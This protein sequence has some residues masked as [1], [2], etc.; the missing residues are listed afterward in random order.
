MP[1]ALLESELFGYEAGAFTDARASKK[2]LLEVAEGGTV[3]LDEIGDLE[4]PVQAKLLRVLEDKR[5]R[6][7]GG[8]QDYAANVRFVAATNRPLETLVREGRF[9]QDLYFRLNVFHI[10]VGPLRERKD[11]MVS[12]LDILS[13]SSAAH[14]TSKSTA[15]PLPRNNCW[16]PM[17]GRETSENCAIS[18]SAP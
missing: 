7:L 10:S 14:S 13:S 6:R 17:T 2:G 15:F 3:F 16:R 1:A 18:S 11:D 9:R 8:T 12:W 5:A 4:M